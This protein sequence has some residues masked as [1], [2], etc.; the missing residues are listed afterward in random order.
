[1]LLI[2]TII[3]ILV[4]TLVAWFANRLLPFTICPICAG[5]LFTWVGLLGLYFTGYPIDPVL[6]AVLMGGSVVGIM[7]QVDKKLSDRS[8]GARLFFKVF[9]MPTGIIAA[10]SILKE[11]WIVSGLALI[12]LLFVSLLFLFTR[13]TVG[14]RERATDEI[15]EKFENCC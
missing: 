2:L 12:V 10:Y 7:Y 4:I 5:S 9:F 3:S 1:M 15:E 14:V 6:P 8:A 11:W 13:G